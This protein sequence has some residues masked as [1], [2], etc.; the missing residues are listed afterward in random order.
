MRTLAT[1]TARPI[2]SATR[3]TRPLGRSPP[4][5][6]T[7]NQTPSEAGWS[8]AIA[9]VA[10]ATPP[11]PWTADVVPGRDREEHRPV[12]EREEHVEVAEQQPDRER[13][14]ERSQGDDRQGDGARRQV[15][16]EPPGE[17]DGDRGEPG[18]RGRV[19]GDEHHGRRDRGE[20]G[21]ELGDDRRI[22]VEEALGDRRGPG[23]ERRVV[24]R[25]PGRDVPAGAEQQLQ[26]EA[27]LRAV[28][29]RRA[30]RR[31][32]AGRAS[33]RSRRSRAPRARR[34]EPARETTPG[35]RP[36]ARSSVV[37]VADARDEARE[38]IEE[39]ARRGED[40]QRHRH[41]PAVA[42]RRGPDREH[43]E[44]DDHRGP[45]QRGDG[46]GRQRD[47][48]ADLVEAEERQ[49][50]DRVRRREDQLD[51]DQGRDPDRQP[52][53]RPPVAPAEPPDRDEDREDLEVRRERDRPRRC[54]ARAAT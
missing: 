35:G 46:V 49:V 45:E 2:P 32:R 29:R 31:S 4:R 21:H 30:S 9:A 36:P 42:T 7:P 38:L 23:D 3:K 11:A 34:T 16:R 6:R 48:A 18:D 12:E 25:A 37:G 15:R 26:V 43:D 40:G 13:E 1:R 41:R 24:G 22:R 52:A 28:S 10:R 20:G 44:P 53:E 17:R 50:G 33:R 19:P 39:Q 51:A 54:R 14:A 5:P 47:D 8:F 27:G